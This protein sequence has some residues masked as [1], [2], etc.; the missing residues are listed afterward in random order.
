MTNEEMAERI[1]RLEEFIINQFSEMSD[2]ERQPVADSQG[3]ADI[4]NRSSVQYNRTERRWQ[5]IE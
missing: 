5:V 3:Y 1:R 2:G 4:F